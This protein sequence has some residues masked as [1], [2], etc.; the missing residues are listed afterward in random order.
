MNKVLGILMV[1]LGLTLASCGGDSVDNSAPTV[2]LNVLATIN[3]VEN[4]TITADAQDDIAVKSVQ[5]FDNGQSLVID[6]T[7]PYSAILHYTTAQN[8]KHTIRA[9]VT[10]TSNK[11]NEVSQ[12]ITV[13]IPNDTEKPSISLK[14]DKTTIVDLNPVNI[15]ADAKDNVAIESV[16]FYEGTKELAKV[17]S[18]PYNISYI[19]ASL[20]KHTIRAVAT[21]TSGNQQ[22][23]SIELNFTAP[24]ADTEKPKVTVDLSPSTINHSSW[25]EVKMTATAKDNIAIKEVKFQIVAAGQTIVVATVPANTTGNYVMSITPEIVS[26]LSPMAATVLSN[27]LIKSADVVVIATDTSGNTAQASQT[28]TIN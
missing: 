9:V 13:A 4:I 5:F 24:T 7:V 2:K 21:D 18:Q 11:T 3:K 14:A 10:D 12:D 1:G 17:S 16:V 20:G 22:E 8:G 19:P 26:K 28:L 23:T 6:D 25:S 27:G 15:S